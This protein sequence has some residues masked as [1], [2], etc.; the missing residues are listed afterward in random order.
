MYQ[1]LTWSLNSHTTYLTHSQS[2]FGSFAILNSTLWLELARTFKIGRLKLLS[3]PP[4]IYGIIFGLDGA[5]C[6]QLRCIQQPNILDCTPFTFQWDHIN[7]KICNT[8]PS[9]LSNRICMTI[10]GHQIRPLNC[11]DYKIEPKTERPGKIPVSVA[12]LELED[13]KRRSKE[14][15]GTCSEEWDREKTWW[16]EKAQRGMDLAPSWWSDNIDGDTVNGS[17]NENVDQWADA[18]RIYIWPSKVEYG[19]LGWV[20]AVY[21]LKKCIEEYRERS[22][23]NLEGLI[24]YL[25]KMLMQ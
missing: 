20:C 15:L 5:Q 4:A 17:Q 7:G 12:C 2:I 3:T 11:V 21:L 23:A 1:Q 10:K 18:F 6:L 19:S 13:A 25:C 22:V 8:R 14:D 24:P 9:H 16:E